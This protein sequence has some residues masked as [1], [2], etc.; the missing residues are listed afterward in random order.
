MKP[1]PTVQNALLTAAPHGTGPITIDSTAVRR[2]GLP[3]FPVMGEYHFSRD[4]PSRWL[5]ELRQMRAGGVTVV[6]TYL[7]WILHEEQRGAR[8][9]A[10]HLDVRRFV[11]DAQRAGLEVMLRIGPWAHGEAR[12]GGF[13]DWLQALPIAHRTNDPDYLTLVDGWYRDIAAELTGLFRDDEHPD[14]PI[15]GIQ[16]D[17]EL[18]DQP[19]HLATLREMAEAAGMAAPLWVATGWGGAQLPLERLTPVYAGYS[20]AF[21]ESTEIDW[22]AYAK[23]HFE[24]STVRDDLSVGA[25]VRGEL[26][27]EPVP[28]DHRYAYLTCELGGGM[29]TAYH[30]RPLVDAEDV[31]AL[32]ITKIG[33]GSAWQGYYLYHGTTQVTGELSGTQ[34]SHETDYP[35]DMPRKDYDFYAPIG[36]AGTLRPHYHLLRRQHLL[37]NTWGGA[38]TRLPVTLPERGEDEVRW[39]LRADDESGYIFVTNHQPAVRPLPQV[40]GV[41]FTVDIGEHRVGVPAEDIPIPAGSSFVW[42]VRQRYGDITALTATVQPIT[43]ILD[44]GATFVFFA[45]LPGIPVEL[46]IEAD[47]AVSGATLVDTAGG[48]RWIPD[49]EP[50]PDCVVRVGDTALVILDPATSLRLWTA[51]I[52]GRP[53]VIVFDGAVIQADDAVVLERWNG[54]TEVLTL[55]AIDGRGSAAIGPF[56]RFTLPE[57]E[58]RPPLAVTTVRAQSAPAPTRTG[59]SMGRL[60]APV[61]ADFDGAAVFEVAIDLPASHDGATVL[62]L[63]WT[64]DVARA[65]I[66]GVLVADQFWH[67]RSWEIELGRWRD[68]LGS[69]PLRIRVLPW[70]G[71]A[72]VYVDARVRDRRR[73]GAATVD[74]AELLVSDTTTL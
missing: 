49:V 63:G 33:S 72:D 48:R 67:G 59:G 54:T 47:S 35:N 41:R 7:I 27:T 58:P 44:A 46:Q 55:P 40:D 28:E 24:Y 57:R 51:T 4:E 65:E 62:S 26:L 23:M 52:D 68:A 13:P 14:A 22:P 37:L 29:A 19:D 36:A 45:A 70:N 74:S 25:D 6:A 8:S 21:W 71:V 10:G 31:G 64:G 61:D 60:S 73:A 20:D 15:I 18:Y 50:G 3:W 38:L 11:R 17:N 2:N 42:P 30:R 56:Q 12:N 39:A 32:G 34:E 43:E 1:S 9:F 16:V 69:A 66:G 5:H 53:T